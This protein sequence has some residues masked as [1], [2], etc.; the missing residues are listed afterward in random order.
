MFF[1]HSLY[2]LLLLQVF[3]FMFYYFTVLS[4]FTEQLLFLF[5]IDF[6]IYFSRGCSI[7]GNPKAYELNFSYVRLTVRTARN[8]LFRMPPHLFH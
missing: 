7:G 6:F 4:Y 3:S 8:I 1:L 2:F 5:H